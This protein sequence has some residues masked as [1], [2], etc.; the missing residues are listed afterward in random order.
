MFVNPSIEK[1][2]RAKEYN[3]MV[4]CIEE[5]VSYGYARAFKYTDTPD[6]AAI[7]TALEDA[8]LNVICENFTFDEL[9]RE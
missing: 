4:R 5:G 3:L 2:M 8:I 9:D 1:I 7:K 6:E